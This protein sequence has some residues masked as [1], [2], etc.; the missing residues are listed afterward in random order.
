M[1]YFIFLVACLFTAQAASSQLRI[2]EVMSNGGTSDW[3]ELTN[4]GTT[5]VSISGYKMDD[6]SF[7]FATSVVLNGISSI[8]PGERVIF[9]ENANTSYPATFRTFWGLAESIQVGTYTGTGIGLSSSGDGVIVFDATGLEVWRVSFGA[10]TAGTSFY[11]GYDLN[12]NF[13][14]NYV[15]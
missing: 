1:K 15:G 14:P 13:D 9:C 5:A 12:G 6:N 10:A 2:T 11:W 7:S 4:Y 3:F 8:G